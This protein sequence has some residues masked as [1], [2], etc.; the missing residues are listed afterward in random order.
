MPD[1]RFKPTLVNRT[2]AHYRVLAQIGKGGMGEV[3]LAEDLRL[4]RRVALKVLSSTLAEEPRSLER[5]QREARSVAALNHPNI[6]TL[7]S[8][9]ESEGLHFLVM[10]LVEGE[11]L[12]NLIDGPM[13]PEQLL[14]IALQLAEA[15]EAAHA[16]GIIHRD[17]KPRNVMVTPEGRVKVLDFGI[18][19]L[20][21]SRKNRQIDDEDTEVELTRPGRAI[22]TAAYMSPEQAEGRPAD[23]RSDLFSLGVVLYE[24]ATGRRPFQA[25]SRTATLEAI[26]GDTPPPPS[27]LAPGLPDGFDKIVSLCLSKEP[28]LRYRGAAEIRRDL[29]KLA[30][31]LGS[32]TASSPSRSTGT[33]SSNSRAATNP[34]LPVAPR[35]FGREAEVRDL[36]AALCDDPPAPVPVLGP[37]GSG[38]TTMILA[39]L[40]DSRVAERFGR[41]RFFVRCDAATDR[42]G[43]IGSL[44]RIL[45]PDASPPLEPKVFL[46]LEEAPAVLAIDNFET[47]WER[48]TAAVEDLL[49][50]IAA[51]PWLALTV[52][53]R[54][55]QRPFGPRWREAVHAEPLDPE[56]A[57]HAFLAVAGER[58][59]DDPNLAP[60]L[61]GLD[62]LALAIVLL[63][64]QAEGEPD[65]AGLR[66]QWEERRTA[67][68]RRAG[69]RERQQSLEVSLELSLDSPR[70]SDESRR[71]FSILGLLPE[72]LA[73]GD[74]PSLLPGQGA[75]AASV[76]RKVG[77][78]FD[79]GSRLRMLAPVREHAKQN[80]PPPPEDLERT[81]DHYLNVARLG[82]KVG[83]EGGAE[84]TRRLRPESGNLEPMIL[85][86]LE[87]PDPVPAIHSAL[88]HAETV[89]FTG[90]GGL[91]I[92]QRARQA[93]QRTGEAALEAD[94][95]RKRGDIEL[96]RGQ[97]DLA[98]ASY[99]QARALYRKLGDRRGEAFCISSLGEIETSRTESGNAGQLYQQ[100]QSLFRNLGDTAGEAQCLLGLG[101]AAIIRADYEAACAALEEAMALFH[102]IGDARGEANCLQ[103]LAQSSYELGRVD[104]ARDELQAAL[105]LF[106]EVGSV[107]GSANCLKNMGYIALRTGDP[108]RARPLLE[109]ALAASRS[110][111]SFL[112]EANCLQGLGYVALD[113]AEHEESERL[114]Q[115]ARQR[116]YRIGQLLGQANCAVSLGKVAEARSDPAAARAWYEEALALFREIPKPDSIGRA[117]L[118]LA[119][120]S[121]PGSPE[122]LDAVEAARQAWEKAGL[123][124]Q[125]YSEIDV[126]AQARS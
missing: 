90:L 52:A 45:C 17:L 119:S 47:P 125:L 49:A 106:R 38:K 23:Q 40:H 27:T 126:I 60:L 91:A 77:L 18:A 79:Q 114:L 61:S 97:L 37:A 66:Q 3:Y 55:E 69:A 92:L 64:S 80:H 71:L 14:P 53:L 30:Q 101:T 13:P 1:R 62:G 59:R 89:R 43:L 2:L 63:A 86:G 16:R 11:M 87:R 98:R 10:E 67:L 42:D 104:A 109:E 85:A 41:R 50:E 107:L 7:H 94:C 108:V 51:L 57:R 115:Q 34:R 29:V 8:V 44:A 82:E 121:P 83:S 96:Y 65:L 22:G 120:L 24:I 20:T 54:G 9:E 102:R 31:D 28:F 100:A 113:L 84:A 36:V 118:Y 99:E 123:L 117:C 81:I 105:S 72:G 32:A 124:D 76:L 112:A 58:Y 48:D 110:V 35:C 95:L 25:K 116:F 103:K 46:A 21:H 70:M 93:A 19:R 12:S 78:A 33:D 73:R 5:F 74:L 122:R 39:A 6:V 111:G 26:L 15:L 88:S 56:S 68:L 75:E 4:R